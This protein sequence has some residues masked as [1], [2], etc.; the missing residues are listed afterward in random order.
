MLL[1]N[2]AAAFKILLQKESATVYIVQNETGGFAAARFGPES[3][4]FLLEKDA[5]CHQNDPLAD[6]NQR[7]PDE[8]KDR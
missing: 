8:H 3:S 4:P 6:E 5:V 1:R 7:D 2:R